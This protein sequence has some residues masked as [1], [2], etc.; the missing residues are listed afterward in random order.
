MVFLLAVFQ[1]ERFASVAQ[2]VE[3]R[4]ENPRVVGSIPTGGTNQTKPWKGIPFQATCECSSSGR[5]PP[6]QGGGSEF[7]PRHSLH[8][9]EQLCS[10]RCHSQVVRQSSAKAPLPSSNLGG[11]SKKRSTCFAGASFFGYLGNLKCS[12]QV[13]CP[14]AKVLPAA[15]RL[16]GANAPPRRAGPRSC[17][18]SILCGQDKTK[19]H[20]KGCPFVLGSDRQR[21]SPPFGISMLGVGKAAP[22]PRFSPAVKTLV[23]RTRAAGQKAGWVQFCPLAENLKIFRL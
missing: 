1:K 23:R 9:L 6:C 21:R 19:G 7:E 3:Q 16:Y 13:N 20:P 17:P 12:G 18:A 10:I 14:C 15:K 4:T 22:A 8:F 5:A 2:L 11:T